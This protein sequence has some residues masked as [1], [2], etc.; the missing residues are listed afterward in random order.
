MSFWIFKI[1][2]KKP[3]FIRFIDLVDLYCLYETRVDE[4]NSIVKRIKILI[5]W[6]TKKNAINI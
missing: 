1:R 4:N 2:D 3:V 6:L 5:I